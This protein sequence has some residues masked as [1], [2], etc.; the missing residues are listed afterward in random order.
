AGARVIVP[1]RRMDAALSA[2]GALSGVTVIPM[3]LA[4]LDSVR[5]AAERVAAETERLELLITAAGVM[6]SPER[7]VGPGWESQFAINHLGHFA[8]IPR[9]FPLL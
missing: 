5:S 1:A 9:L 4:D 8:L 7:R 3:D 6:A 2:V